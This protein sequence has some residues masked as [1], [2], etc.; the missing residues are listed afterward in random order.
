MYVEK[1]G[2]AAA[3]PARGAFPQ[4][5]G[6]Y[7]LRKRA[8]A[9]YREANAHRAQSQTRGDV[10]RLIYELEI[11]QL[12]LEMQNDELRLARADVETGLDR[13]KDLY[14]FA[15]VGYFVLDKA[16]AVQQANLTGARMLGVERAKLAGA[17]LAVFIGEGDTGYF[18]R[19]P[20]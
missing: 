16:G 4:L 11:H 17:R 9:E 6:D 18:Q 10:Q 7:E 20:G 5:L 12:E 13:Y 2:E 19:F 8:E 14:D 15:P 1:K 3:P